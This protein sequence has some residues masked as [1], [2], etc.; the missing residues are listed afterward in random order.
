[1]GSLD[2]VDELVQSVTLH[3]PLPVLFHGYA[4]PFVLLYSVWLYGWVVVY[5][6]EYYEAGLICL[7]GIATLQILVCLCCH[8]SVHVQSFLTCREVSPEP[9]LIITD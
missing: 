4:L 1:M 3:I 9:N 6:V 5:G 2:P 8:W 7:A